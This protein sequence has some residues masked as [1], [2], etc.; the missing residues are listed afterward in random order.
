MCKKSNYGMPRDLELEINRFYYWD[1]IKQTEAL[2]GLD[3]S[4]WYD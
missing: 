1:D 3:L 2:T 4:Y